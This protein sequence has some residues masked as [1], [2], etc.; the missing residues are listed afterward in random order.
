MSSFVIILERYRPG[1]LCL[2]GRL[3]NQEMMIMCHFITNKKMFTLGRP[4]VYLCVCMCIY[5]YIYLFI[6]IIIKK[7][8]CKVTQL[9]LEYSSLLLYPPLLT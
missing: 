8:F 5:I 2:C 6:I 1:I 4:S 3:S 9:L 7:M